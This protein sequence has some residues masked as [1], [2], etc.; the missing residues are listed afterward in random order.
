MAASLPEEPS[1]PEVEAATA[2][3]GTTARATVADELRQS[4]RLYRQRLT[5]EFEPN[6]GRDLRGWL[7]RTLERCREELR[8]LP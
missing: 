3:I 4:L 5:M 2:R 1:E 7:E 8:A 6:A